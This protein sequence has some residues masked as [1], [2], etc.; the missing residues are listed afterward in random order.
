MLA[1]SSWLPPGDANGIK[2]A[3][4]FAEDDVHFFERP[5]GSFRVEEVDRGDDEGVAEML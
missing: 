3:L 2:D 5:V 4:G 1:I